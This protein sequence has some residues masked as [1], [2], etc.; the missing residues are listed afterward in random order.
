MKLNE[1]VSALLLAA[2]MGTRLQPLT[3]SWPKSLMPVGGIPL[4]EHW[5]CTLSK[6]GISDI[7]VNIHHHKKVVRDFLARDRFSEWINISEESLLLGTAGTLREYSK[8]CQRKTILVIHADNWCQ[9]DFHEFLRY[10]RQNRSRNSVI[11]MMTFRT[12]D[13][14]NCGI[15]EVNSDGIVF[16]LHEKVVNPPGNLANGAVYLVESPVLAWLQENEF[17]TDF[18]TEVLPH[19]IG[20]IATWENTGIHRDIGTIAS[21]RKAQLDPQPLHCWLKKDAWQSNFEDSEI[22]REL[23]VG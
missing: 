11:T 22:Y 12:L 20:R 3:N 13:P 21:L 16:E 19:F 7:L 18:S 4:L 8:S 15:V 14:E 6:I 9:C 2:G 1:D 10:H 17:V 5:L 23:N